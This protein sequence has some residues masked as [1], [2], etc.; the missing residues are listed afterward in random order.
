MTHASELTSLLKTAT[1]DLQWMSESEY[2]F[3]VICW[4]EQTKP[5]LTNARLLELTH[6]S[7]DAP[8]D[9]IDV[10]A[11][12]E[13]ATQEQDWHGE[14][15]QA[16]VKRY[17]ALVA[18]LKQHLTDLRVYRVGERTIDIY[19]VGRTPDNGVAGLATKAVET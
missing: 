5:D 14:E 2:P 16:I 18:V 19:I 8:V 9:T 12:F 3:D 6:H 13:T 1:N 17:Q 11:F 15:E 4:Q 7:A 10:D